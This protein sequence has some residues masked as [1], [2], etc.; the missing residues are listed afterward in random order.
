MS[1]NAAKAEPAMKNMVPWNERIAYSF[2][3]FACNLSFQ[4]V[5]TYLM[6]LYTDTFGLSAA[7]VGTLF[8]AARIVD[9]FDGPFWGIMIDHTH[10]KWGKSRPYWLWFSIPFAVFC[11]LVFT[12]PNM[13]LT[14]KLVWAYVTYIGVDVLYSAVNIPITSILPSLTSNPQ[15][16]VT[17]STIRQFMGTAGATLI[18][19]ITLTMVAFFGHGSTTSARGWFIWALIVA[20]IVVVIFGFVFK[21]TTERVQTKSSRKSIPIKE[22]LKAL[23]RN[24][25]WA[26]I[27]FINFIYWMGMQTRSQ[28]TVYFFKYNMHDATLASL[29]L[30]LQLVALV[31]VVLT[32]WTASR[33][34]KRNTMLGGMILAV[35]GQLLLSLGANNL[36]VPMII[37]ATIIG[38]LGTGYVSGL[39]AVMLA[40]AVDYGEWINGV[41]AEGIVTSFSSFSAKLGMGIGGVIT[42][43]ILT[44]TG[45]VANKTQTAG[46]L[47]GIELNYIWVPL[48]G[49]AL[50]GIALMFYH[51]DGIEKKMQSDLA[52]KHAREN[53]EDGE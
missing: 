16:R 48:L 42:G 34:G 41:R 15:E 44:G 24:W 32:P 51:V 17:L 2:S 37:F 7:A 33:I 27:I 35:I 53:A 39:I 26:I 45:Y 6:I 29:V 47:H 4:M 14:G 28:V 13:G 23:K 43:W 8:L 11:V 50:S 10:T 5:G 21:Y 19:G 9:A 40:D 12:T 46:A 1:E 3:D 20:V 30:S 25:P 52:E 38:Y 18:T 49:F 36:S 31:A 22:S